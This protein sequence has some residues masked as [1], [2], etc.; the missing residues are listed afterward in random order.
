MPLASS[1]AIR[2]GFSCLRARSR[3]RMGIFWGYLL[4]AG[5]IA[6]VAVG[7]YGLSETGRL[8]PPSFLTETKFDSKNMREALESLWQIPEGEALLSKTLNLWKLN[9]LGEMSEKLKF[10]KV[11]RTDTVLTRHFDPRTK[12]ETRE[13]EVT[14]YLKEDQPRLELILDLVHELVHATARPFFD[15]YDPSL[16]SSK[17]IWLAI[18]GEG[19]EVDAVM[20]ECEFAVALSKKFNWS[21]T[22]CMTYFNKDGLLKSKNAFREKVTQD[23]YKVG[24]WYSDLTRHFSLR[25]GD[26]KSLFPHLSSQQPRFFSS[27]GRSP[28]PVSLYREFEEITKTA[29]QNSRNRA[30]KS[31]VIAS[32]SGDPFISKRCNSGVD[33]VFGPRTQI[34]TAQGTLSTPPRTKGLVH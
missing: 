17:Y 8:N 13:R 9:D 29:C 23:F 31:A 34:N 14:I 16:T 4:G 32:L 20:K 18:E 33:N 6:G 12:L 28:Y 19:G 27:T 3:S 25:S 1:R 15:P 24:K 2:S 30:A 5:L 21:S 22:R 11:S 26:E 7:P 10:D